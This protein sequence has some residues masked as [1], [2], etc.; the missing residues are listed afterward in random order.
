MIKTITALLPL[1]LLT[2]CAALS[3]TTDSR[4]ISPA[5]NYRLADGQQITI[6]GAIHTRKESNGFNATRK[7]ALTV[8]INGTLA[9][10]GM[11]HGDYTGELQGEW[12]GKRIN[13]L[14]SSNQRTEQRVYYGTLQYRY[15]YDVRCGMLIDGEQT[16]TLTF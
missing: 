2:G 15:V 13:A 16:V 6:H 14:C 10:Q 8:L 1:A 4:E 9:L 7:Q 12:E 3:S 5:Q 11:L